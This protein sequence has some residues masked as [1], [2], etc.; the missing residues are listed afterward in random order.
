MI[1]KQHALLLAFIGFL[2]TGTFFIFLNNKNIQIETIKMN[3]ASEMP[4]LATNAISIAQEGT[5]MPDGWYKYEF[6]KAHLNKGTSDKAEFQYKN[7]N[8][9]LPPDWN[10]YIQEINAFNKK[11]EKVTDIGGANL[12]LKREADQISIQQAVPEVNGCDFNKN[13]YFECNLYQASNNKNKKLSIIQYGKEQKSLELRV[14]EHGFPY[15]NADPYFPTSDPNF[16]LGVT[17][18]GLI[19]FYSPD[20]D[21]ANIEE[22]IEIVERLEV[23]DD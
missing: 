14:C 1:K 7:Y 22:F 12:F 8:I 16:C 15:E 17:S 13:T 20:K 5:R 3:P 2:L 23:V 19:Q 11:G 4:S 21:T 18:I 9:Y 6:R 10:F